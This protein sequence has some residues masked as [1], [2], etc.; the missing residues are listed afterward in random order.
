MKGYLLLIVGQN[1]YES[2]ASG[3]TEYAPIVA[4]L[5]SVAGQHTISLQLPLTNC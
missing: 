1:P 3:L 2:R 5:T 4:T